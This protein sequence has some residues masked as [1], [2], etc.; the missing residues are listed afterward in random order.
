MAIQSYKSDNLVASD[1]IILKEVTVTSGSSLSRGDAV[2]LVSGKV[3]QLTTTKIL[4][5]VMAEDVDASAGDVVGKM[6]YTGN[7]VGSEIN[8][9]TGTQSEH[10]EQARS[11]G[12]ILVDEA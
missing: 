9:G 1:E 12:I 4:Y 2:E 6:F 10:Q 7:L 8:F 5:G 11:I 3:I